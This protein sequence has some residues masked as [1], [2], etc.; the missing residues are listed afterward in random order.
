M[1]QLTSS[2]APFDTSHDGVTAE[3]RSV[4]ASGLL[5]IAAVAAASIYYGSSY[6]LIVFLLLWLCM[7]G[8][9]M[10]LVPGALARAIGSHPAVCGLS[11]VA[12]LLIASSYFGSISKESSYSAALALALCPIAL[13]IG[14]SAPVQVRSTLLQWLR[15]LV[16]LFAAVSAWQLALYGT[17][18]YAPLAEPNAYA[19]L[20]YLVGL[21]WMH[22]WLGSNETEGVK[23]RSWLEL[24]AFGL[25]SLAAFATVSRVGTFVF[26]AAVG[27]WFVST[28][29]ARR[30]GLP[31][32]LSRVV[33]LAVVVLLA[34]GASAVRL[35][36]GLATEMSD[37]PVD[38]S[39]GVRGFLVSSGF[40]AVDG[41][42]SGTG[43][44]T[45]P[46]LYPSVRTDADI[47]SAGLFVHNDYVQFLLEAGPGL[48]LLLVVF[49]LWV[50]IKFCTALI[51]FWRAGNWQE[52]TGV[53]MALGCALAHSAVNFIFYVPVLALIIGLLAGSLVPPA[54]A[55]KESGPRRGMTFLVGATSLVCGLA[56]TFF[57]VLETLN[58]GVLGGQRHIP[59]AAGCAESQECQ[60]RFADLSSR[61]NSS[62]GV[63]L[64]ARAILLEQ[65]RF[66]AQGEKAATN[67]L[68]VRQSLAGFRSSLE[69]DPWNA[70]AYLQFRAFVKRHPEVEPTLASS[71]NSVA[72]LD[73]ALELDPYNIAAISEVVVE[74]E[75]IGRADQ[76]QAF[77]FAHLEYRIANF[78]QRYPE[79]AEY[80]LRWLEATG[81]DQP[82][83]LQRTRELREAIVVSPFEFTQRWWFR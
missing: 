42:L 53:L 13:L 26:F 58:A 6:N 66:D 64:L 61:L 22:S 45:F 16:V 47:S 43:I 75:S 74:L 30:R 4:P 2:S 83:V 17:R 34:F 49:L 67:Q 78:G 56:L 24:F 77:L 7:F 1:N 9:W 76:A 5:L 18:A 28:L 50:V 33:L 14:A 3:R 36:G 65:A 63:P 57:L 25:I 40:A 70:Q 80:L 31:L 11:I 37:G 59:L 41:S 10:L 73:R 81:A 19:A 51:L 60:L 62:W 23:G 71:E 12:L 29:I 44:Y 32:G 52:E 39:I 20:L 35:D 8:A 46:L 79:D 72:L 68:V 82:E 15:G 54:G 27:F 38:E 55:I 21:P 48:A 69:A